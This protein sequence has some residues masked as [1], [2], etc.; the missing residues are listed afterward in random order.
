MKE[1]KLNDYVR[2]KKMWQ[3]KNVEIGKVVEICPSDK[4]VKYYAFVL[5][6]K[7][8][9]TEKNIIDSSKDIIDLVRI[10]DYVNGLKVV[11]YNEREKAF[12][13]ECEGMECGF[14]WIGTN[15]EIKS[16]LTKEQFETMEY[17]IGR[18]KTTIRYKDAISWE[19]YD[20]AKV[21]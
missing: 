15:T 7:E 17:K 8:V 21:E 20:N 4:M 19:E 9:I 12:I 6:N 3:K 14:G 2:Y 1:P 13:C 18:K 5:D 16:V 11:G 10:G